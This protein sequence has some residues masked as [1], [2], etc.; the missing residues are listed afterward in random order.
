[1]TKP[2]YLD[3]AA[4]TPVDPEVI[5]AM[6]PYFAEEYGNPSSVHMWGQRAQHAVK[7]GREKIAAVLNCSADEIIFT[8]CGSESDN[9]AIR[10]AAL[11]ARE[12]GRGSHIV[13]SAMEHPAVLNT[14]RSLR[15]QDGFEL[16]ELGVD[17]HGMTSTD[18][19]SNALRSD[20]VLV[21]IMYAN[22]EIGVIAPIAEL[23]K[24]AHDQGAI[25]HTDA[26]QAGSQLPLDIEALGVDMLSLGAHKF[27]G[28]KGVGVLYA[29]SGTALQPT[30]TGGNQEAG[31]RA[32]TH[33]V[34]L[35]VGMAAALEITEERRN[36]DGTRMEALRDR[37]IKRILELVP[38]SRLTGHRTE[39]LPNNASF[40]FANIDG[41]ELLMHLDLAGITAS[42]GSACKT[43]SPE[44]STVTRS[45]RL[46]QRWELG[47]LRLSLGR[48]TASDD[49][50]YTISMLPDIIKRMRAENG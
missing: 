50:D 27:Y 6:L 18:D 11:T 34:P 46:S 25:F 39:R 49:I 41:N 48:Y 45:L 36:R 15:D 19:L 2:I 4:T 13:V 26:V 12:S 8:A 33:N 31:R 28:P 43:G 47:S 3:H 9:L 14:A 40:V 10:G 1:M 35:I 17:E 5:S 23:A 42:S 20:T 24:A 44:P 29:R 38:D 32:G 22:N 7:S 30:Q 21:S 16:T 37:L